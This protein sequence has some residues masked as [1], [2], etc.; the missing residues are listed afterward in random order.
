MQLQPFF[1][2]EMH[3]RIN[4]TNFDKNLFV[5]YELR[6]KESPEYKIL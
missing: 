1:D 5:K 4:E 2:W 6:S 3:V